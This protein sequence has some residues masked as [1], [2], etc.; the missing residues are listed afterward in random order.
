MKIKDQ[1]TSLELSKK[2]K[3]LGVFQ[4]DM[5]NHGAYSWNLRE[6]DGQWY[7]E[8]FGGVCFPPKEECVA[9]TVAELGKML[10]LSIEKD[11]TE[12]SLLIRDF[13]SLNYF[14]LSMG[15]IMEPFL[16]INII[17]DTEANARAKMLIYL[18][19]KGYVK[20]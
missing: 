8:R 10:P 15:E 7:L 11:G 12:Y 16:D 19:E 6:A 5:V 18:I 2:L 20:P 4:G 9:F 3:E 1:V 13:D 14:V 17:A